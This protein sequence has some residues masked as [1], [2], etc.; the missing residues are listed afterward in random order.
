ML[1]MTK[2]ELEKINNP[3]KYVFEQGMSGVNYIN[4]RYSK[5][6]NKCC[7]DYD[8]TK[9]EKYIIYLDMLQQTNPIKMTKKN[10]QTL[11]EAS[12][13]ERRKKQQ[14]FGKIR[15]YKQRQVERFETAE[16]ENYVESETN[17]N[18]QQHEHT[19]IVPDTQDV[20]NQIEENGS[21]SVRENFFLHGQGAT[22]ANQ[23]KN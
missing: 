20:P 22:K 11:A 18:N 17:N 12:K 7:P 14:F 2:I 15:P 3:D 19:I 8:K 1:K 6:N 9:P 5:A 23:R 4:K 10:G 16:I 13:V 21:S